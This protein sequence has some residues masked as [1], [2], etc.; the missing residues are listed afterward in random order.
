MWHTKSIKFIYL[1]VNVI[2]YMIA[3]IFLISPFCSYVL[4]LDVKINFSSG[5]IWTVV[6]VVSVEY[7]CGSSIFLL[8][9]AG[10]LRWWLVER[11]LAEGGEGVTT[12][13]QLSTVARL[14]DELYHPV[15][16]HVFDLYAVHLL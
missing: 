16:V 15:T 4:I 3:K 13:D 8:P 12:N 11:T 2:I 10:A 7:G 14:R 5:P 1:S 9:D 6:R